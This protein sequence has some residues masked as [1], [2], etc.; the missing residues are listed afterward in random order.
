MRIWDIKP[1]LLCREH[2]LGEHRELHAIWNVLTMGKKGYSRHP[3]TL[4]WSG[5]QKALY[6]VHDEI[7]LE[8][9]RRGYRHHSP[10]DKMLA[11]GGSVQNVYVNTPAEQVK[12][13]QDKHCTCRV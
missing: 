6:K 13:L 9:I 2:L 12:I 4:R 8:M 5:K 1:E 10:L 11:T 7:V 3:E